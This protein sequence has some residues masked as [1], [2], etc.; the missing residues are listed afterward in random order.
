MS[1][2]RR[3]IF[4][5]GTPD[6][7]NETIENFQD[8]EIIPTENEIQTDSLN[9]SIDSEEIAA[10]QRPNKKLR[11]RLADSDK[12]VNLQPVSA[13]VDSDEI[14]IT[15]IDNSDAN[16]A[17]ASI[18]KEPASE[19]GL[20]DPNYHVFARRSKKYKDIFSRESEALNR[21]EM[22]KKDSV[23]ETNDS[24]TTPANNAE[25][26]AEKTAS[27]DK[28]T[29][30]P[31]PAP[32]PAASEDIPE[33]VSNA[34]PVTAP[35]PETPAAMSENSEP[36]SGEP[37]VIPE[38]PAT[39]TAAPETA[40]PVL[41]EPDAE[42]P[43]PVPA[44]AADIPGTDTDSAEEPEKPLSETT[45]GSAS[46][47]GIFAKLDGTDGAAAEPEEKKSRKKGL[48]AAL[49][50]LL[51][52]LCAGLGLNHFVFDADKF[53]SGSTINS[54]DVSGLTAKQAE[55][56]LVK[57]WKSKTL[58]I[59]E[60]GKTVGSFSKVNFDYNISDD[61]EKALHP[62][63]PQTVKR[64]FKK[65]ERQYKINAM[66]TAST[67]KFNKQF[68]NLSIVKDHKT[69]KEEKNA[70]VDLSNT[71]FKVV[72]EVYGDRLNEKKLKKALTAALTSEKQEFDYNP[73][74][75]YVQ[76]KIKKN[77]PE[78]KKDLEYCNKYLK[79]KITYNAPLIKYTISPK[80]LNKLIKADDSGKITVDQKKVEKFVTDTLSPKVSTVG[81]KRKLK[82]KGGGTYTVEGGDYGLTLNTKKEIK[83]LTTEL[84]SGQDVARKPVFNEK[85][86]YKNGSDIGKTYV[87]ID[88]GK[89]HVWCVVNG[90]TKVSA[91]CVS[92]NP[93]TGHAT[94]YGVYKLA[95]KDYN[96]TLTGRENDGST[97]HSHVWYWMPFN[98]GI[99]MHDADGWRS[100]Y[101]GS[102][103]AYGGS[104]G[105]VNLPGSAA[106]AIW[107]NDHIVSGTPV[108]VHE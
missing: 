93:S 14:Q 98:G 3:N 12:N 45:P 17:A 87:E 90:K 35:E 7:V 43:E 51:A 60:D 68:K 100:V 53:I 81:T 63:F 79:T 78:I 26:V 97:Y 65:K 82:S 38:T 99:G 22:E 104:H 9:D 34:E 107:H 36:V 20:S 80:Q 75:Y 108:I 91:D 23:P 62:G 58:T 66:P 105:C 103:Y 44:E 84:E 59:K 13:L 49:I 32:V 94:P 83:K 101:G 27:D 41:E 40:D 16:R 8:T 2:K 57:T 11:R 74:E 64:T 15:K 69:T 67:E 31:A 5:S 10:E 92:G 86:E 37:D 18:E 29:P 6:D 47:A 54:I 106:S 48:I 50:A 102:I 25:P 85:V 55:D 52:V 56:K 30:V 61:V 21:R 96:V 95:Y 73:E 19:T 4:D 42:I 33:P 89:Q 39:D 1:K 24:V 76:P 88:I 71:D 46:D 72:P 70:Y 28:T 77:S